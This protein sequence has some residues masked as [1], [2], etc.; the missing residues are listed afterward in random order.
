MFMVDIYILA[1]YSVGRSSTNWVMAR[2]HERLVVDL[3]GR[4]C[5]ARQFGQLIGRVNT[6][7]RPVVSVVNR[8]LP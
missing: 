7:A 2:S 3:V 1:L 4:H 8:R 5:V 6:F